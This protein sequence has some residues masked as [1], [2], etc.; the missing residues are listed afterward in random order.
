MSS[1]CDTP[2]PCPP[3]NHRPS[4]SASFLTTL[5]LSL[6]LIDLITSRSSGYL[7]HLPTGLSLKLG[8]F[9]LST[10]DDI[11]YYNV[12][13]VSVFSLTEFSVAFEGKRTDAHPL[14]RFD[15]HTSSRCRSL[16]SGLRVICLRGIID[17]VSSGRERNEA[18]KW[19]RRKSERWRTGVESNGH[20]W[21][22]ESTR[23]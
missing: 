15:T 21:C 13:Q 17:E 23:G 4:T 14:E 8:V 10:L 1:C 7:H 6:R 19:L 12:T 5:L 16:L 20:S 9:G 22:T 11:A 3:S 2:R 18:D